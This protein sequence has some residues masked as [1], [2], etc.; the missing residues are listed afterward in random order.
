[1]FSQSFILLKYC[2][3][4]QGPIIYKIIYVSNLGSRRERKRLKQQSLA[5]E[6]ANLVN[7]GLGGIGSPGSSLSR[8]ER[9]GNLL[10]R[11]ER[12]GN[13]FCTPV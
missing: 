5:A 11:D 10:R 12:R 13:L 6:Q 4:P 7:A 2:I 1:M 8:D 3:A 9:K